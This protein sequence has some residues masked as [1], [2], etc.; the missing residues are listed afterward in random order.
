MYV[1]GVS[2]DWSKEFMPFMAYEH[3][4]FEDPRKKDYDQLQLGFQLKF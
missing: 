3:R 2:Y 4:D 1:L